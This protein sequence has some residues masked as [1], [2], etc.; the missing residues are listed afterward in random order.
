MSK[1]LD[2]V[3]FS[4]IK[5]YK[6]LLIALNRWSGLSTSVN[7]TDNFIVKSCLL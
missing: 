7:A 2:I 4:E 3:G 5:Q 6:I 1:T